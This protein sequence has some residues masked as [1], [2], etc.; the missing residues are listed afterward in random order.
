MKD[1]SS[2]FQ[3]PCDYSAKVIGIYSDYFEEKII[4][5]TKHYFPNTKI[6]IS[7]KRYSKDHNYLAVTFSVYANNKE[8]ID[9][10]YQGLSDL[11]EVLMVL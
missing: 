10:L 11:P 2:P 1:N 5:I 8:E 6:E 3:F 9:A 7:D 4:E